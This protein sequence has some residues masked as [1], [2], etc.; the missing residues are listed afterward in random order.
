MYLKLLY[1]SND[2]KFPVPMDSLGT[3]RRTFLSFLVTEI[4]AGTT[5]PIPG[6]F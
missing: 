1:L 5:V 3:E 2:W 4:G 6:S